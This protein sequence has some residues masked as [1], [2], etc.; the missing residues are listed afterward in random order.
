LDDFEEFESGRQGCSISREAEAL[1]PR[2]A[3]LT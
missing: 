2:R 3:R 1:G